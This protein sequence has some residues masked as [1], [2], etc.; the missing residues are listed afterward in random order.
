VTSGVDINGRF[1]TQAATGVQR[2]AAQVCAAM[3]GSLAVNGRAVSLLAPQGASDPAL[4]HVPLVRVGAMSGHIWEQL[5]LPLNSRGTL[6]SLCNTGPLAR[7][8]QVL[9]IHDANVF[10]SPESYS[11]AFRT[12]YRTLQPLLVRRVAR[13][14]TVSQFSAA[15]LARCF[16]LPLGDIA[17]APNGHEHALAWAPDRAVKAP[18]I[19]SA[20]GRDPA[21]PFVLAIGSRARH[22]NLQL[23]TTISPALGQMGLD[24]VVAGGGADIFPAGVLADSP[25]VLPTGYVTDDD[26][27]YLLDRAVCL[28]FPSWTEGFGLPIVEAMARGCPVVS[29]D[30]ASMPEICGSAASTAAPDSPESWIRE[31][32]RL[33]SQ[34][35]LR[36]DLIGAG[37]EQV[38]HFSWSRTAQGY[39]D[40]LERLS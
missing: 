25:G 6:L 19:L 24:V 18:A 17:V 40:L 15:E 20:E 26:L 28:A 21:R 11:R 3:D 38:K 30:R 35:G 2:Y 39:L 1:L 29:S 37:R 23:L 4:A 10:S 14:T 12:F 9:C 27:A 31:I 16:Q 7:G 34:P 33:H 5:E 13:L 36:A 22:K 8:R 32:G